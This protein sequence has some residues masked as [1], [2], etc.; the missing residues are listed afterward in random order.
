MTFCIRKQEEIWPRLL[1]SGPDRFSL[2][3]H[4]GFDTTYACPSTLPPPA[5]DMVLWS[6][7][8]SHV[9]K[10]WKCGVLVFLKS[11]WFNQASDN[12]KGRWS[13]AQHD[14]DHLLSSSRWTVCSTR[15]YSCTAY[16][17]SNAN[18]LTS[19]DCFWG[20]SA[21][22]VLHENAGCDVRRGSDR[23]GNATCVWHCTSCCTSHLCS[24]GKLSTSRV[25]V[26]RAEVGD[27]N[28]IVDC[29]DTIMISY[30]VLKVDCVNVVHRE[31]TTALYPL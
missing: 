3:V 2:R 10:Q 7:S 15:K 27:I 8:E 28:G 17:L 24:E 13:N 25:D 29:V 18:A 6:R 9:E 20:A 14:E 31:D 4:F 5:L 19:I 26:D 22:L 11:K 16:S 12:R 23:T 1:P 21:R 30:D